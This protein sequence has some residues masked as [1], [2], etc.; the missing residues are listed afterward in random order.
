MLKVDMAQCFDRIDHQ[1][2]LATRQALSGI[3]RQVRAWLRSGI[4]E[5]DTF[6]P[7]TAGTPQ[8]GSVSP[9][10]ALIALHGMDAAITQIYPEARVIAY[11]D[12]CLVLHPD[13][14]VLDH[15]QQRLTAWLAAVGLT[16]NTTK[17]RICHTLEGEQPGMDF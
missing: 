12:D 4:M 2:L 7:T 6:T 10:L 13:R 5:A 1:A 8:G 3:R 9:L 11:A 14:S 17:T 15:C 16:L